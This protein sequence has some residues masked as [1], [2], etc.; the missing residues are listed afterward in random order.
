MTL[1]IST[2]LDILYEITIPTLAIL[3][4]AIFENGH[5]RYRYGHVIII[6]MANI[7]I[8]LWGIK[9]MISMKNSFKTHNKPIRNY[10]LKKFQTKLGPFPLYF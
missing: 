3:I 8:V 5:N 7:D 2:F 9:M 1:V 6:Y 4:V 10:G